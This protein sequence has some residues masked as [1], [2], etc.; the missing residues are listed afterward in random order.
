MNDRQVCIH[1]VHMSPD[2]LHAGHLH[3]AVEKMGRNTGFDETPVIHFMPVTIT[4]LLCDLWKSA[5][6]CVA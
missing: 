1:H 3:N 4:D 2:L 6:A 5:E